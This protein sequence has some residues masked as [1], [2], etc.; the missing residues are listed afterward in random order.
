[1]QQPQ[2][3]GAQD[4]RTAALTYDDQISRNGTIVRVKVIPTQE[5]CELHFA[6]LY[7]KLRLAAFEAKQKGLL[8]EDKMQHCL[9]QKV[10][11]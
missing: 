2:Q 11:S 7:P 9:Q 4:L 8:I 5:G 6:V 1:M 3:C 10:C